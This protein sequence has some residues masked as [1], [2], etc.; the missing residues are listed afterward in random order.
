MLGP[1]VLGPVLSKRNVKDCFRRRNVSVQERCKLVFASQLP[2][3]I[4]IGQ[5][6]IEPPYAVVA[7]STRLERSGSLVLCF[8]LF[9]NWSY[10]VNVMG[11]S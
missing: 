8:M 9:L 5:T 3:G 10:H 4:R 11:K 2:Q 1:K 6:G 7:R